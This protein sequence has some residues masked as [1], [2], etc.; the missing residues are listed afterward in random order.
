MESLSSCNILAFD[1]IL[2]PSLRASMSGEGDTWERR[3]AWEEMERHRRNAKSR[4]KLEWNSRVK[5]IFCVCSFSCKWSHVL[6][7]FCNTFTFYRKLSW[8][9][10]S[11]ERKVS[12][13]FYFSHSLHYSIHTANIQVEL[14]KMLKIRFFPLMHFMSFI[15]ATCCHCLLGHCHCNTICDGVLR[16]RR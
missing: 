7:T 3:L 15:F 2:P 10:V 14:C 12:G 8:R 6:V 13:D 5:Y 1:L 11:I 16:N 9:I 4:E